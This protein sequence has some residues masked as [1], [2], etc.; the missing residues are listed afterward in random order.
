MIELRDLP[1]NLS[2]RSIVVG[3]AVTAFVSLVW[4][5]Q[6]SSALDDVR[7]VSSTTEDPRF[8][9]ISQVLTGHADLDPMTAARLSAGFA[10]IAPIR[11]AEFRRLAD[12][13]DS[14]MSPQI[15]LTTATQADLHL[16]ALS[17][18]AA[19]YTGTA[20]SGTK[21][22]TV[23]YREALMQRA[24]ADALIAPTYALGGPGW[25]T[26]QPPEVGLARPGERA[27]TVPTVGN[28]DPKP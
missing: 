7:T 14:T 12:V 28:P 21:A 10:Q 2:R 23:S 24:V 25:W 27:S 15:A 5:L 19:W 26:A 9:R 8:L 4:S 20:G 16:T 1:E 13:I 6:S 3:G 18:V 22:I 17:I 11:Y